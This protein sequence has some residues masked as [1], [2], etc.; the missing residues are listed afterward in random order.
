[1]KRHPFVSVILPVYNSENTI[2][3]VLES[4]IRQKYPKNRFEIIV[5]DNASSDQSSE[6]IQQFPVKILNERRK[7]NSYMA[8]NAGLIHAIG[9][10]IVFIDADC[11]PDENWLDNLIKPFEQKEIGVVAGEV[12]SLVPENLIQGFYS[13]V[14]FLSQRI[15]VQDR[16]SSIGAGNTAFRKTIFDIVG[17]FDENFRWGGD[18]DFGIRVQ[19]RTKFLIRYNENARVYHFHRRSLKGLIIQA[20]NY[21][22]GKGRYRLKYQNDFIDSKKTSLIWNFISLSKIL[23][24]FVLIPKHFINKYKLY[25]KWTPSIIYPFLERIF[26]I[27]EQVGILYFLI[28]KKD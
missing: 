20:F 5:V 21:G 14:G 27:F 28:K 16:I 24:S 7:K 10:I 2:K 15:K 13:D 3:R 8:R 22:R 4:A 1:M 26:S 19:L 23:V 25:K 18:N 11:I 9:E 6:I 17:R 12:L